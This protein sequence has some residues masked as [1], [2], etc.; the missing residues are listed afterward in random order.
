MI[1]FP[2]SCTSS[3]RKI[4]LM[5]HEAYGVS[6]GISANM[7]NTLAI[8]NQREPD[9]FSLQRPKVCQLSQASDLQQTW[10][11]MIPWAKECWWMDMFNRHLTCCSSHQPFSKPLPPITRQTVQISVFHI[12]VKQRHEEMKTPEDKILQ[13]DSS[14]LSAY[15]IRNFH[16]IIEPLYY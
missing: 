14:Q 1:R 3:S 15:H 9:T 6:V 10:K 12:S 13:W 8:G 5:S 2:I 7:E 4:V 11:S 16:H